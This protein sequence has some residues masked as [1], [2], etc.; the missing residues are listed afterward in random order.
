MKTNNHT[1]F[2]IIGA[3]AAGLTAAETLHEKGYTNVLVMEKETFA[4][5][6]CRSM[7]YDGRSYELGAGIVAANNSTIMQLIDKYQIPISPSVSGSSNLYNLETADLCEDIFTL[8]E[9]ISFL[10]QLLLRYHR[11]LLQYPEVQKTGLAQAEP[12]LFDNFHHWA[13]INGIDLVERNFERYFTG[14]GYG[15]WSEIP[16]AYSVKYNSWDTF[17]SF[18]RGKIYS[19][20]EGIQSLWQKVAQHHHVLYDTNIHQITRNKQGI[21]IVSNKGQIDADVL[22]LTC[23]LDE[24]AGFM[25]LSNIE[26]DLFSKIKYLDY[27][28]YLCKLDNFVPRT[29]FIPAHF[30]P[31][32]KGHPLFWYKRYEDTNIYTLYVLSD[33]SVSDDIIHQNI[34]AT[35]EKLGGTLGSIEKSV[36]WKYFPH[37]DTNTMQNGYYPKLEA[38]QGTQN[39]YYAGELFNFSMVE[40]TAAYTK[41]LVERFF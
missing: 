38:L 35:I 19:F 6:K 32:K 11:L 13:T 37:V 39:T 26:Q 17:V 2:V 7:T 20:D 30:S 1:R 3:G 36:K 8:P 12:E 24:C 14:F 25:H 27:R 15:Y 29:G 10:W 4:G 40:L 23:P 33:F 22:L 41:N 18:F 34:L 9:K 28:T 31:D 21:S 16:A 5:G